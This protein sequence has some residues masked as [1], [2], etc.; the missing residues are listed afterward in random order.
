[1]EASPPTFK[2]IFSTLDCVEHL[3]SRMRND[4]NAASWHFAV[5]WCVIEGACIE[6]A[7]DTAHLPAWQTQWPTYACTSASLRLT[8]P[9]ECL[10]GLRDFLKNMQ[11][12]HCDAVGGPMD[13]L[14]Y[15]LDIFPTQTRLS[16]TL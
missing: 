7:G 13:G 3:A 16:I 15:R 14:C 10:A 5:G 2:P 11:H 12:T 4:P 8:A 6:D 9:P 1:M